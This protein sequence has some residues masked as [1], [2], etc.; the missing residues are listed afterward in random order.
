MKPTG[1]TSLGT[2]QLVTMLRKAAVLHKFG[3]WKV[4]ANEIKKP[5]RKRR[6]VSLKTINT[7]LREGETA[8]VPGKV[9]ASGML[10]KKVTVAAF[11]Y[12]RQ[13]EEKINKSG[14]ALLLKEFLKEN[15]KPKNARILG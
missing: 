2:R 6:E 12:S 9:L 5:T 3:L 15:P 8:I 4:V 7:Y 13:A 14:K 10:T 11:K 1:P